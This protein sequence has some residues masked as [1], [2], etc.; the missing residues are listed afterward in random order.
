MKRWTTILGRSGTT[1]IA[2]SLALLLVSFVPSISTHTNSGNGGLGPGK[3]SIL[4][5][6][7]NFNPQQEIVAEFTVE[8]TVTLYL[9]EINIELN[10][11]PNTGFDYNFNSTDLEKL[12]DEQS[13]KIL[14]EHEIENEYYKWSYSPTRVMNATLVTYNQPD[15]ENVHYDYETR[16]QSGLAPK[17]KV[18]TIAYW[19]APVGV[20]LAV[21]WLVNL[22][23]QRKNK[24]A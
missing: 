6:P 4:L 20:I 21:P 22:W 2:I 11:N 10:F 1:L 24:L 16:V 3:M 15:S 5:T 19:V 8:G 23:K 14:W 17:D 12:V 7:H 13:D 18:R 9:V